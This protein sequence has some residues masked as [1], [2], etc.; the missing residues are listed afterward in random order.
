MTTIDRAARAH[1]RAHIID[2]A[3]AAL[4]RLRGEAAPAG[5]ARS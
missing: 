1:V 3:T 4:G 2:A 5:G